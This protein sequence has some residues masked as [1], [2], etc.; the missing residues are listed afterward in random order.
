MCM[1]GCFTPVQQKLN[2]AKQ[3]YINFK[4]CK[5]FKLEKN[6][7]SASTLGMREDDKN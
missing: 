7:K 4:N 6:N 2:I 3:L 5:Y 1:C